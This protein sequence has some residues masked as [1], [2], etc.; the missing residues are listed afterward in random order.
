[1]ISELFNLFTKKLFSSTVEY[2]SSHASKSYFVSGSDMKLSAYEGV[3][4]CQSMDMS[5]ASP[6]NQPEYDNIRKLL[7]SWFDYDTL[8]IE[9]YRSEIDEHVW[10]SSG[11]KVNYKIAF[12]ANQP[13]NYKS[14]EDCVVFTKDYAKMNDVSCTS[15]SQI[16]CERDN[17]AIDKHDQK[18]MEKFMRP[19]FS[20]NI[21][22]P[23]RTIQKNL[24]K[25]QNF[26]KTTWIGARQ[27]CKS[28]GMDLI[29]PESEYEF[30]MFKE[31]IGWSYD[32]E[33]F[34]HFG[35]TNLNAD[36]WYSI[37]SGKSLDYDIAWSDSDWKM[38]AHCSIIDNSSLFKL[39]KSS[40]TNLKTSF[41]C[42]EVLVHL[43][44]EEVESEAVDTSQEIK[45]V[46]EKKF[47]KVYVSS[48]SK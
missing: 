46:E 1:M 6:R 39:K 29:V 11:E 9:A 17:K 34:Y 22:T 24:Y 27:I 20:Y 37:A 13:D 23:D 14:K 12:G 2:G 47:S 18:E 44:G 40:C 36:Q 28:F 35:L 42:Q 3:R 32:F 8:L 15:H 41:V 31:S 4:L 43:N 30:K 19:S 33:K 21:S 25:S 10:M 38:P 45:N 48:K 26:L 5:L 7:L 16:L